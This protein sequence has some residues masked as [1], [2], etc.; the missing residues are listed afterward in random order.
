MSTTAAAKSLQPC[1]TLCDRIDGS[2]PGSPVPGILQARTLGWVAI[3]F[4]NAWKWKVKVKSLSRVRLCATPW[5]AAYQAPLSMGFSRQE[6][7]SGV[8]WPSLGLQSTRLQRAD[9][10]WWLNNNRLHCVKRLHLWEEA[11]A[12]QA[13]GRETGLHHRKCSGAGTD[14]FPPKATIYFWWKTFV[15]SLSLS[16][17]DELRLLNMPHP[18]VILQVGLSSGFYFWCITELEKK[19]IFP[20]LSLHKDTDRH[21]Q[22]H[23]HTHTHTHTQAY[24][25]AIRNAIA[26]ISPASLR[27]APLADV[28]PPEW[29]LQNTEPQPPAGEPGAAFNLLLSAIP[30]VPNSLPVGSEPHTQGGQVK[31]SPGESHTQWGPRE[32]AGTK[33]QEEELLCPLLHTHPHEFSPAL[34]PLGATSFIFPPEQSR[35]SCSSWLWY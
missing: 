34:S 1:P 16:I 8:P 12:P 22:V 24:G 32:K 23:T 27:G 31:R 10:T 11:T 2:P 18:A 7:W 25:P 30:W 19:K 9:M 17:E 28:W 33:R 6:Y 15:F 14:F 29:R 26:T 20:A 3:S 4:T 21:T 35:G 13:H 5:T